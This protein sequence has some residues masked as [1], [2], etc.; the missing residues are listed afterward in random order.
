MCSSDLQAQLM[1]VEKLFEIADYGENFVPTKGANLFRPAPNAC[2]ISDELRTKVEEVE[3]GNTDSSQK[4]GML[5]QLES[6]SESL[7][8]SP[9]TASALS[10]EFMRQDIFGLRRDRIMEHVSKVTLYKEMLSLAIEIF[11]NHVITSH[12]AYGLLPRLRT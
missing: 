11:I 12:H 1:Q 2:E 6:E 8:A 5:D 7:P 10:P 9:P 4:E 3:V